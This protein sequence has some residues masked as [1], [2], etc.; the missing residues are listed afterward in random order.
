MPYR[1]RAADGKFAHWSPLSPETLRVAGVSAWL[2]EGTEEDWNV[3]GILRCVPL[4]PRG[5]ALRALMLV[6]SEPLG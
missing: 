5:S 6:A 1:C 3:Y 2:L 4:L